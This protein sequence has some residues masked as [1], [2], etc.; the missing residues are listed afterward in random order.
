LRSESEPGIEM[1]LELSQRAPGREIGAAVAA[2]LDHPSPRVRTAAVAAMEV[3]RMRDPAGRIRAFLEA[4]HEPLRRAAVAYVVELGEPPVMLARK[5]LDGPDAALKQH[6]LEVLHE[7]PPLARVVL[8][9]EWITAR[10]ES[11][12]REERLLGARALS[13]SPRAV[14]LE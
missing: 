11:A 2:R 3:R 4:G 5:I 12:S 13:A 9:R 10:L 1:A 6:L 14:P 8:G 7:R